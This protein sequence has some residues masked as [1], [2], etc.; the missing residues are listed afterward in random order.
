MKTTINKSACRKAGGQMLQICPEHGLLHASQIHWLVTAAVKIIDHHR[1]LVL[2]VY[3]S[4]QAAKGDLAPRWTVYQTKD[5]YVTMER[6]VDGSTA[7]RTAA[8][9]RLSGE[10]RFI[11]LCAFVSSKDEQHVTRYFRD[12]TC[13]GFLCL[14]RRQNAIQA[15]RRAKREKQKQKKIRERMRCI[16]AVP[17]GL[18]QWAQRQAMPAYWFY[19]KKGRKAT[20]GVC[21]ACNK[22]SELVEVKHNKKVICPKCG[23]E[24]TCKSRGRAKYLQDRDTV[25][26]IQRTG[27]SELVVR[28]FKVYYDYFGEGAKEIHEAMR[29]F[30]RKEANGDLAY[31]N[32]YASYGIWK[33]GQRPLYICYQYQFEADDF[34][35]L[36]TGNLPAALKDTP[37]QYTPITEF[38]QHFSNERMQARPFLAADLKHPRLEH[39]VKVGFYN[40]ASDLAYRGDYNHTL[41]ETQNRTHRILNVAAED[42]PFLRELDV[43]MAMIQKFHQYGSLKDRQ[44]LLRWQLRNDVTYNIPEILRQITPHR[45]MKYLDQQQSHPDPQ[46]RERY[47]KM[48]ACVTEYRDYLDLCAKLGDDLASSFVLYPKNLRK[49]HDQASKR[50]KIKVDKAMRRDFHI[51]YNHIQAHKDFTMAG[52]QMVYPSAPEEIVHEGQALHHCVA[53]YVDR[54]A[55][56]KCLILFLRHS[57]D[58]ATPF[59]TVEVRGNKAVQVRGYKNADPTP[60]VETFMTA[61]ERQVLQAA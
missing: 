17:R 51:A 11:D 23:R 59:Y 31:E 33:Q 27:P 50:L 39:L 58:L 57:D 53:G 37:W 5:D 49:A 1:T 30:I 8:F 61:W 46:T 38:A 6:K 56:K 42:V 26:V 16:P 13:N 55:Q 21:S 10:W 29:Q 32:Y 47:A 22:E 44:A 2:N 12:A 24:V 60:E 3:P 48:Q 40:L 4:E 35:Y 41:D 20:T 52:L 14:M 43:D 28:I 25:Q 45:M 7:W 19:D 36:Y 34:A 9:E 18:E 15:Q 54:V